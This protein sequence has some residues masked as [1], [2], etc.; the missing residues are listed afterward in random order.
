MLLIGKNFVFAHKLEG[1]FVIL[2][3]SGVVEAVLPSPF[4]KTVSI[5]SK[6][7]SYIPFTAPV[8]FTESHQDK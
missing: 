8:Y 2:H 3:C 6:K 4:G 5:S 1:E 7:K